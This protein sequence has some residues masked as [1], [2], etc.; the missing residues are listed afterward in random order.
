M[1]P[2]PAYLVP[3]F[4]RLSQSSSFQRLMK[5]KGE[6]MKLLRSLGGAL[7]IALILGLMAVAVPAG[8]QTLTTL[9]MERVVPLTG[10]N[11]TLTPNLPASTLA[12]ITGGALEIHEQTNYNPQANAL[13]STFFLEPAGT[14]PPVNLGTVSASNILA[15]V[16]LTP[17]K[18]YVTTTAVQ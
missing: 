12:S 1:R 5:K 16:A 3:Y 17:D 9:T 8:A 18:T 13:T 11:S 10:F 6:N 2:A 15:V 4:G 14:A 7:S